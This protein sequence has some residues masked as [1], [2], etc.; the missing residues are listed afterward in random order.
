MKF[1]L[2]SYN[3][4][5]PDKELIT[6][7][8]RVAKE[9]G[10]ETVGRI[11][12]DKFGKFF[13]GTLRKRFGG[14]L[15]ALEKAG[16]KK[17]RIYSTDEELTRELKRVASELGKRYLTTEDFKRNSKLSNPVTIQHRFGTWNNALSKA[18]LQLSPGYRRKYS[19][20]EYFENLLNVWTY[21]GRQ[22][23]HGEMKKF[24]S[25]I[26]PDGYKRRFGSWRKAL[27]AF[28]GRMNQEEENNEQVFKEEVTKIPVREEIK[29]QSVA[30]E[31]RRGIGL[32]LRYKV[33]SRDNFRCVRCGR[34]PATNLGVELHI[35]HKQPFS[36]QGKTTIENLET[37]C[38]DCNLGKSNRHIE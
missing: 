33:L 4:D 27:E 20:E 9:S 19:T 37:K 8:Q 11:E 29:R 26:G 1:E 6:D 13:E 12:Y 31:D 36:K 2:K 38:K 7:L 14:W 34:S 10:K 30:V 18:G 24:P 22:P 15:N 32:G 16:L 3:R 5:I 23:T 35:D 28:V 25:V 17:T 21:H